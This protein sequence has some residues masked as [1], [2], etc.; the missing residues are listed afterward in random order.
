VVRDDFPLNISK[1]MRSKQKTLIPAFRRTYIRL[2]KRLGRD[3]RF[4]MDQTGDTAR[5]ILEAYEG[6][7][8]DEMVDLMED[9]NI[10]KRSRPDIK[11]IS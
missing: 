5:V 7:T 3:T 6:Y 11:S 10:L 2:S 4:V 9:D 1:M 8:V